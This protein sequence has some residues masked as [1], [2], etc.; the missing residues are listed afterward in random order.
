MPVK[1]KSLYLINQGFSPVFCEFCLTN[2]STQE[3]K[4]TSGSQTEKQR[5]SCY[6]LNIS[7]KRNT[8]TA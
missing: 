1:R 2:G 5:D 4:K 3:P 8:Q 6:D 7:T